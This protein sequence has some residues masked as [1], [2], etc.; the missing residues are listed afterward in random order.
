MNRRGIPDSVKLLKELLDKKSNPRGTG[1]YIRPPESQLVYVCWRDAK[2]VLLISTAFPGHS[3]STVSRKVVNPAS[4][5]CEVLDVTCPLVR[6]KYNK[7]MGGVDKSDQ[8]LAYHNVLRKTVRYWKTLF[9]HMVDI[10]IVN[11]FI[12]YNL[13]AFESGYR[14]ITENDF[15]D[16][17]VTQMIT[18]SGRSR[19]EPIPLGHPPRSDCRVRHGSKL[20]PPADKTRCQY[21]KLNGVVKFTQRKC[22]DCPFCPALCQTAENDCHLNWHQPSFDAVRE[23]WFRSKSKNTSSSAVGTSDASQSSTTTTTTSQQFECPKRGRPKGSTN[24]RR[25]RGGYRGKLTAWFVLLTFLHCRCA[26]V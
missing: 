12:I 5:R 8:Y 20:Y 24:K 6:E 21:C 26:S 7:Y 14:S 23:L 17:L 1:Y 11:A 13:I 15:R 25:R 3:E 18:R 22:P 10:A 4:G 2:A 9:Y 19:S 16:A